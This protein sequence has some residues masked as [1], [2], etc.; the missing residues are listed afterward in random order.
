MVSN[1]FSK[2]YLLTVTWQDI[3]KLLKENFNKNNRLERRLLVYLYRHPD[4]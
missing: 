2:Y 1:E 4:L 3:R